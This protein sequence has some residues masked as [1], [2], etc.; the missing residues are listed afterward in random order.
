MKKT[1]VLANQALCIQSKIHKE[2]KRRTR[3]RNKFIYSETN[4]DK[5]AYKNLRNYCFSLIQKEKSP[6]TVIIKYVTF[7]DVKFTNKDFASGKRE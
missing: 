2:I 6:I 5:I 7:R 3:L 1:Y 4:T